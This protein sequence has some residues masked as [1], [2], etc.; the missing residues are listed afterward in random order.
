MKKTLFLMISIFLLSSLACTLFSGQAGPT[1]EPTQLPTDAQIVTPTLP[2]AS[3]TSSAP[4]TTQ[5]ASS[6]TA[7]VPVT[8]QTPTTVSA[9]TPTSVTDPRGEEEVLILQPGPGSRL[10]GSVLVSGMADSTFEQNLVVRLLLDDGTELTT[11]PTTI[12]AE[13]GQRGPFEVEVPFEVSEER[14]AFLQVFHTSARDGG[15]LH[16]ASVGVILAPDGSVSLNPVEPH[17]ERIEIFQPALGEVV[18]G[19]IVHVEGFALASFEQ[20]LLIEVLDMD[21]NVVGQQ[22]VIVN[23]PDLGQPGPF[24]ADIPYSISATGPGR[25][26]VRDISPAFGGDSHVASVEIDLQ[27]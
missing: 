10:V 14:Q 1:A 22:P 18:S 20:S 25:I 8:S 11:V 3:S 17:P 5:P 9:A 16:L 15:L 21:G 24:S 12:R 2:P 19:G 26:L 23:A 7:T 6:P 13:L 27:P 4:A